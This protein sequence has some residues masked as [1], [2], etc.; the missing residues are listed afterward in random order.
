MSR[1]DAG[2]YARR[3]PG[4]GEVAVETTMI[5]GAAEPGAEGEHRAHIKHSD[6]EVE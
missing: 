6:G 3:L 2:A 5:V 1:Q 4:V